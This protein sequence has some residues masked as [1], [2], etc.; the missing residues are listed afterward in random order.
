MKPLHPFQMLTWVFFGWFNC[1]FAVML[2]PFLTQAHL[3][4]IAVIVAFGISALSTFC[5]AWLCTEHNPTDPRATAAYANQKKTGVYRRPSYPVDLPKD[6]LVYCD[7]CISHVQRSAK[8]CHACN[9]CVVD[10]DHHC[11]FVN[12]CIDGVIYRKFIALLVS[13]LV[14]TALVIGLNVLMIIDSWDSDPDFFSHLE[15][16]YGFN[17]IVVT[18]VCGFTALIALILFALVG[19][20]F[21][22]HVLLIYRGQ[23]TYEYIIAQRESRKSQSSESTAS[24]DRMAR[25]STTIAP[26]QEPV[27]EAQL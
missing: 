5:C 24:H 9:R 13:V 7:Y 25:Q 11:N 8:H 10:F 27:H 22:F 6:T 2:G 18:V 16:A 20:L 15:D 17:E 1:E 12:N 26:P 21:S 19:Q 4:M 14:L 23:T 3:G